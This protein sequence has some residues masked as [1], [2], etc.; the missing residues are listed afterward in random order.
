M[1]ADKRRNADGFLEV[2]WSSLR[3]GTLLV[4]AFWAGFEGRFGAGLGGHLGG[5]G[6]GS[7]RRSFVGLGDWGW[8]VWIDGRWVADCLVARPRGNAPDGERPC[9]WR[10]GVFRSHGRW[11]NLRDGEIFAELAEIEKGVAELAIK[12]GDVAADEFDG[13]DVE[14]VGWNGG[15][16]GLVGVEG[17][18]AWE[19][20]AGEG[21][22]G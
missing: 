17:E 15:V 12:S 11:R 21:L 3:L 8:F 9:F 13:L 1:V 2:S 5:E 18:G 20:I 19:G 6:D 14:L 4:L 16:D 22:P 10:V 7:E